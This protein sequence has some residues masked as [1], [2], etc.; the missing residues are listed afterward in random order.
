V[1]ERRMRSAFYEAMASAGSPR[2]QA[3]LHVAAI[4]RDAGTVFGKASDLLGYHDYLTRA[5]AWKAA[6]GSAPSAFEREVHTHATGALADTN[7][8]AAA[9]LRITSQLRRSGALDDL[10]SGWVAA[11][12]SAGRVSV[13]DLRRDLEDASVSNLVR[14]KGVTDAMWT[15]ILENLAQVDGQLL[16]K[17]GWLALETT[18]APG[19]T[20]MRTLEFA[21]APKGLPRTAA[22][23]LR[24]GRFER[25]A[26]RFEQ[27]G[28]RNLFLF[29]QQEHPVELSD[30]IL[31][32]AIHSVRQVAEHRRRLQDTGLATYVGSAPAIIWV[33]AAL[34]ALAIGGLLM[35]EF[36]YRDGNEAVEAACI[37]GKILSLLGGLAIYFALFVG[38]I[39]LI[40]DDGSGSVGPGH[41]CP[42]PG[43]V[44][45]IDL[46]TLEV[47]CGPRQ[48]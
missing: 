7:E 2:T 44:V 33:M 16:I 29:P 45:T 9:T 1:T 47:T 24:R 3:P 22:E 37:T 15:S 48:R 31:S 12:N 6:R 25:L 34:A 41:P 5:R 10:M 21:A 13:A 38:S 42:G 46:L 27:E 14:S 32:G 43:D 28:A 4:A 23:L 20:G 19:G 40:P 35:S 30:V 17:G 18:T 8:F 26:A 36:C 11:V 39:G